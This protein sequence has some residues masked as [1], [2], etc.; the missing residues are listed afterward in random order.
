LLLSS[1]RQAVLKRS[2]PLSTRDLQIV[3]SA[4]GADAGVTGAVNLALDRV[5][6]VDSTG[7]HKHF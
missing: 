4:I 2:L 7:T 5:F 3:F 6:E 1:I